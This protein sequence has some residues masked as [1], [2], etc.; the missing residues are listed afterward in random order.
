MVVGEIAVDLAVA[1][2]AEM[3]RQRVIEHRLAVGGEP[4]Q[5]AL[6]AVDTEAQRLGGEAI[7]KAQAVDALGLCEALIAA[8][9]G[10]DRAVA[11]KAH[12]ILHVVA[13]AVGRIEQRLRPIGMEQGRQG[14][15]AVMVE[16]SEMGLGPEAEIARGRPARSN[17]ARES[18]RRWRTLSAS[19]Y[20]FFSRP[21]T[22]LIPAERR[23]RP[24]KC[25][26]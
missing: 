6:M 13:A 7:G 5:L 26:K 8:I 1:I 14:M 11:E 18:E 4:R 21:V 20:L 15:G 9:E 12:R 3:P 16:E 25:V 23:L 22:R 17:M 10:L 19:M 24:V 2:D